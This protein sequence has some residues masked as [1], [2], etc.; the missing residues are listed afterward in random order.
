[1][2]EPTQVIKFS[3]RLACLFYS[4]PRRAAFLL[5][6]RTR[7]FRAT[8]DPLFSIVSHPPSFPPP[9]D[10][11]F[12]LSPDTIPILLSSLPPPPLFFLFLSF[13]PH[14]P[15]SSPSDKSRGRSPTVL[16]IQPLS[17]SLSPPFLLLPVVAI[18]F[19][20]LRR[21]RKLFAAPSPRPWPA[22]SRGG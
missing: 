14:P 10:V 12:C 5:S 17:L 2:I 16:S 8:C 6:N 9:P 13:F 3:E 11:R 1:M 22:D 20:S 15:S 19:T 4:W 21:Y 7:P 18:Y